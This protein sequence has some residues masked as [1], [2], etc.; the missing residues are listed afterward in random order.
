MFLFA[1]S[2]AFHSFVKKKS[3][4]NRCVQLIEPPLS[5]SQTRYIERLLSIYLDEND[6]SSNSHEKQSSDDEKIHSL[7]DYAHQTLARS[8]S[9]PDSDES[10]WKQAPG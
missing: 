1:L 10:I 6:A 2:F 5:K 7:A 3:T 8:S 4:F 9:V